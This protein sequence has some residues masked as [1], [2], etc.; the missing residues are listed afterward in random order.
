[1]E[2][3]GPFFRMSIDLG[4]T[5]YCYCLSA[6][7]PGDEYDPDAPLLRDQPTA[8][9]RYQR[10][11]AAQM[12]R[13][14]DDGEDDGGADLE[15]I[16][17]VAEE[18][19][20][21]R[22]QP[23]QTSDV[24]FPAMFRIRR[25]INQP[26]EGDTLVEWVPAVHRILRSHACVR[27]GRVREVYIEQQV[28][29][30]N[31]VCFALSFAIYS[32][33]LE[34][35]RQSPRCYPL[36]VEFV[37]PQEKFSVVGLACPSGKENYDYRKRISRDVVAYLLGQWTRAGL[38]DPKWQR[39]LRMAEESG[40]AD[41]Y[42]DSLWQKWARVL[43]SKRIALRWT[44]CKRLIDW[45]LSGSCGR[46]YKNRGLE[47]TA[48]ALK[49]SE[50]SSALTTAVIRIPRRAHN[51]FVAAGARGDEPPPDE[52]ADGEEEVLPPA[53]V[54]QPS[55]KRARSKAEDDAGPTRS[56]VAPPLAMLKRH[57]GGK[58]QK[59]YYDVEQEIWHDSPAPSPPQPPRSYRSEAAEAR[60][61]LDLLSA[62]F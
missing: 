36:V 20:P 6:I 11:V 33:F 40:K 3:E 24:G 51:S 19:S 50:G 32:F 14:D 59:G 8:L 61:V 42:A 18:A 62:E 35:R 15:A 54:K 60:H 38:V 21:I 4:T 41:D 10:A 13:D 5:N 52:D 29:T 1:M 7:S 48:E 26:L 55:N 44:D 53:T 25:W 27:D 12:L 16:G 45:L 22:R 23:P 34:V 58:K 43:V 37:N 28:G 47:L 30:A 2:E 56:A 17:P 46:M 39:L 49:K 31:P 9:E 57:E